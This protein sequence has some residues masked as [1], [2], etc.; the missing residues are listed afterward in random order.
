M[1]IDTLE[2]AALS[3]AW[4]RRLCRRA[5]GSF[6]RLSDSGRCA[7]RPRGGAKLYRFR[8]PRPSLRPLPRRDLRVDPRL[9]AGAGGLPPLAPA[10][11]ADREPGVA[12]LVPARGARGVR[13]HAGAPRRG[14]RPARGARI[15][16]LAPGAARPHPRE[17]GDDARR[18]GRPRGAPA[19]ARGPRGGGGPPRRAKTR[20]EL[21]IPRRT[22]IS[23]TDEAHL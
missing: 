2:D 21:W 7:V 19:P 18:P 1:E 3:E 23:C 16:R 9:C 13:A 8:E 12:T 6:P 5:A 22:C 11:R 17:P 20:A 14:R 10:G 15:G 4:W